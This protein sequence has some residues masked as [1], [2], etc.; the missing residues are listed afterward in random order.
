M[1]GSH[2]VLLTILFIM[3]TA[4]RKVGQLVMPANR[5]PALL[6]KEKSGVYR[7]RLIRSSQSRYPGDIGCAQD[8]N[9]PGGAL[10]AIDLDNNIVTVDG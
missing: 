9:F 3:V 5:S 1:L 4:R 10:Y 2:Q 7:N 6:R 8:A